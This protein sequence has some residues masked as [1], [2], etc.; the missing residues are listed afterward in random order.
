MRRPLLFAVFGLILAT[1]MCSESECGPA[2]CEDHPYTKG[3]EF[4]YA[5]NFFD[6][7]AEDCNTC[8]HA[9][10]VASWQFPNGVVGDIEQG[11]QRFIDGLFAWE[12][13]GDI[14]LEK[15][16]IAPPSIGP[17]MFPANASSQVSPAIFGP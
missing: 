17:K 4:L 15:D 2:H 10:L 13:R 8:T 11:P 12:C 9:S 6:F 7:I 16:Q 1:E 14:R 3:A 5:G